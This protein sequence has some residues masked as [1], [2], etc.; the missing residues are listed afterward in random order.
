MDDLDHAKL[1][2]FGDGSVM[3]VGNASELMPNS[4][5]KG[6]PPPTSSNIFPFPENGGC[7]SNFF[8]MNYL[9]YH[10]KYAS[11]SSTDSL[12]W[13]FLSMLTTKYPK[14]PLLRSISLQTQSPGEERFFFLGFLDAWSKKISSR[15]CLGA[16]V[17]V[18]SVMITGEAEYVLTVAL[19]VALPLFQR[20]LV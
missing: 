10:H 20:Y 19:L 8:W 17:A 14:A 3:L 6:L 7:N 18:F 2:I 13:E 15:N 5:I 9:Y 11:F 1:W 4:T 16:M 12:A